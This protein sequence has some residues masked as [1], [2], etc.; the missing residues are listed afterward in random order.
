[1]KRLLWRKVAGITIAR[2]NEIARPDNLAMCRLL[3][4]PSE[5]LA[6]IKP[7]GFQQIRHAGLA[8]APQRG[9]RWTCISTW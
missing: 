5:P 9:L 1:M 7:G 3:N 2:S 8:A 6:S 4:I